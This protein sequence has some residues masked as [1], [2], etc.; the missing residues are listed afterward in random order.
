MY[1]RNGDWHF[2]SQKNSYIADHVRYLVLIKKSPFENGHPALEP[3]LVGTCLAN[4]EAD[5]KK[6][7]LSFIGV[8]DE[9]GIVPSSPYTSALDAG[10][11]PR[12][13]YDRMLDRRDR[14]GAASPVDAEPAL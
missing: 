12:L 8:V 9:Y 14:S 10:P 13:N 6:L 11:R 7:A 1:W 2:L 5:A 3:G 4:S